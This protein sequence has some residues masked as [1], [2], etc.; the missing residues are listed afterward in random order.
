MDVLELVKLKQL[1]PSRALDAN[2]GDFGHALIIGGD[3]GMAGAVR[4]AAEA[5]ARTG[6]GLVSVAT[7]PEHVSIISSTRPELLCYGINSVNSLQY[8]LTKATVIAIGPGLGQDNWSK[9]LFS[10]AIN[11]PQPKI[12]DADALNLLAKNPVKHNHWILTPH[13]GEAARLLNTDTKTIQINRLAAIQQLQ[14]IYGGVV[15]LK[16][17]N[18]LVLDTDKKAYVCHAGNPGMASG[19]MGDLLTGIITGLVAQGLTLD[20]AAKLGVILHAYAG[21]LAAKEQGQCGLLAL[22]LI[23]YLRKVLNTC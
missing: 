7:R 22:D 8:L 9:E 2:K 21:D 1:L 6:A 20:N 16:G 18:T 23:P 4:I 12:V 19:G 3:Y 13:P 10:Q 17:F 14:A 5:A 15:V 11:Q